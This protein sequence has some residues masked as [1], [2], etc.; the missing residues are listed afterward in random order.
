[1]RIVSLDE[2]TRKEV[3]GNL[4]SRN[5][6]D[7]GDYE[8]SVRDI[9]DTVRAEGD[10]ALF[11]YTEQFDH[12]KLTEDTVRVTDGEIMEAYSE[13]SKDLLE[14]IR[15]ALKNIRSYHERQKRTSWFDS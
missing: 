5:R 6:T 7:Y 12:V 10:E 2:N 3:L 13:V 11:G 1:M 4:L 14:V 8:K 15:R 9:V